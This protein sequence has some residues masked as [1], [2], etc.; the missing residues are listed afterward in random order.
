MRLKTLNRRK[1]IVRDLIRLINDHLDM[2]L[3]NREL[4][5]EAGFSA[6]HARRSF[7]ELMQKPVTE[8]ARERRLE[9]AAVLLSST[10]MPIWRIAMEC[11]FDSQYG[12]T[13]AFVAMFGCTPS[14]FRNL[15]RESTLDFPSRSYTYNYEPGQGVRKEVGVQTGVQRIITLVYEGIQLVGIVRQEEEG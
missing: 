8:F 12:L 2:R 13:R 5:A 15:N 9:H 4:A 11:G 1:R 6:V 10:T 7:E 3:G 14:D